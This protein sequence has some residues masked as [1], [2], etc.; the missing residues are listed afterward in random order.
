[1]WQE[2]KT[3][4]PTGYS[5]TW[6][7]TRYQAWAKKLDVVMR[8]DHRAGEKLFIDYAGET[9]PIQDPRTGDIRQAQIFVAALG[10][11]SYTYIEA[12]WS[13]SLPD[14]IGVACPRVRV[15]WRVSRD[16]RAR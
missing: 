10:A 7:C 1:M 4:H 13:Q 9:V 6:F 16:S 12:T 2:Y 5:Y 3:Q 8:H 15:L 14:W 11:S